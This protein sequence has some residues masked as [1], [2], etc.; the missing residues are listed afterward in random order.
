MAR[1]YFLNEKEKALV[2]DYVK[3]IKDLEDISKQLLNRFGIA[4]QTIAQLHDFKDATTFD[5]D[6]FEFSETN[7][8]N[9]E[10]SDS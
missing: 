5:L 8:E 6:N 3:K 2:V 4:L 7:E 10:H 9:S 1:S